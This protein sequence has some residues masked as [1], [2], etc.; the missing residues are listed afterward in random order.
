KPLFAFSLGQDASQRNP[1][2]VPFRATQERSSG[3]LAGA[4]GDDS[5]HGVGSREREHG[6]ELVREMGRDP[7]SIHRVN[8]DRK[9]HFLDEALDPKIPYPCEVDAKAR[10]IPVFERSSHLLA[11]LARIVL[12]AKRRPDKA[13]DRSGPFDKPRLP[14]SFEIL[15][16]S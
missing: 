11:I 8:E 1:G 5:H 9:I 7:F 2:F 3:H 13:L 15:L 6:V 4:R 16:A 10:A 14:Q 12:E